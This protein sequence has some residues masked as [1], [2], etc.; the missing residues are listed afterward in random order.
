MNNCTEWTLPPF[1]DHLF[2]LSIPRLVAQIRQH[3][4]VQPRRRYSPA[5]KPR[6]CN[7]PETRDESEG[8]R[9]PSEAS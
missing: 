9:P 8:S 1:A 2:V 3:E 4:L 7:D 6:G 5:A